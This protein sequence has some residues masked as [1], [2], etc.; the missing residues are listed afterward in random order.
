MDHAF[1]LGKVRDRTS[2]SGKGCLFTLRL[3]EPVSRWPGLC[4]MGPRRKECVPG[5]Q[6]WVQ[7]QRH[8]EV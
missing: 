3:W 7:Q 2:L 8:T 6:L 5:I 1:F 4:P